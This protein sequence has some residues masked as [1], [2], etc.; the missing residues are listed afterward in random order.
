M[1]P[2]YTNVCIHIDKTNKD[3][4]DRK[5]GADSCDPKSKEQAGTIADLAT[6]FF[7]YFSSVPKK[8]VRC[9]EKKL[10]SRLRKDSHCAR[11]PHF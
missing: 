3:R 4:N 8:T 9:L 5:K 7:Q 6:S 10:S 1:I 11:K 2:V